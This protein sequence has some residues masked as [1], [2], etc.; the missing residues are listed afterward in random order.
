VTYYPEIHCQV[1]YDSAGIPGTIVY[2]A[3]GCDP[4]LGPIYPYASGFIVGVTA[5]PEPST[6][7][8]LTTGL[9]GVAGYVGIRFRRE[10][11]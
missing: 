8:L 11:Q 1:F 10:K 4:E 6:I 2:E 3:A 7:L 9:V 5:I